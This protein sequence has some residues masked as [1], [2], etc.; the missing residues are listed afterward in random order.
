MTTTPKGLLIDVQTFTAD[1]TWNKPDECNAVEVEV[2]AGSGGG[3]GSNSGDAGDGGDS[4]FGSHCSATGGSGGPGGVADYQGRAADG[5]GSNGNVNGV[6]LPGGAPGYNYTGDGNW[7]H[8]QAGG[9]GGYAYEYITSGLGSTESVTAGSAG[10]AGDDPT[11]T[12]GDA[13]QAGYVIV[14]SYT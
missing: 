3:G 6:G 12:D 5:V 13:G 9:Y 8:G 2:F 10:A 11:F 4:S 14:R 1:G 7:D